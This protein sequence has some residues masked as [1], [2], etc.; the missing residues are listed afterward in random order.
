MDRELLKKVRA[1]R[2][3]KPRPEP[4]QPDIKGNILKLLIFYII[5]SLMDNKK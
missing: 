4:K 3:A 5:H 2:I 1:A